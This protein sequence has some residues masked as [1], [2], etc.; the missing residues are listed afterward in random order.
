MLLNCVWF[1]MLYVSRRSVNKR[2]SPMGKLLAKV[3]SQLFWRSG[4]DTRPPS[5]ALPK[6]AIDLPIPCC[7]V[8]CGV[9]LQGIGKA[10]ACQLNVLFLVQSPMS[11]VTWL[12]GTEGLPRTTILAPLLPS[13]AEPVMFGAGFA[14]V[15]LEKLPAPGKLCM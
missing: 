7:G 4:T 9:Q 15:V 6:H 3:M 1:Q 14:V 11:Y 10:N 5:P 13:V 8:A 2:F 12:V